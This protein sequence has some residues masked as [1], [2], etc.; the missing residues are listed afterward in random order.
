MLIIFPRLPNGNVL[1]T[2]DG[3]GNTATVSCSGT[4]VVALH[5][6]CDLKVHPHCNNKWYYKGLYH[7]EHTYEKRLKC[8]TKNN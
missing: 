8:Y 7:T 1:S 2:C 3:C 5:C 6:I 4:N